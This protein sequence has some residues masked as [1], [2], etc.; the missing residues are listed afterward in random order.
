MRESAVESALARACRRAGFLCF[1]LAAVGRRG[2]PDRT[3]LCPGGRIAFVETKAPKKG[4]RADQR[5]VHR[6]LRRFGFQVFVVDDPDAAEGVVEEI[7]AA[8]KKGSE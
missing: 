5:L 1:K 4:P 8:N 6:A 3:I 2:F 7:A